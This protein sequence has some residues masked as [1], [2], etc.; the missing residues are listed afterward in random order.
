MNRYPVNLVWFKRDLRIR[1]HLPL[2][3][4][5]ESALPTVLLYIYEPELVGDAHYDDRHWRFVWESLEELN[6]QLSPNHKVCI[7]F[8]D[9]EKVFEELN[10]EYTI[11]TVF[12]HEETGIL[13]TYQRDIRMAAWFKSR[14]I[15]WDESPTNAVYR[16]LFTRKHWKPQWKSRILSEPDQPDLKALTTVKL[17]ES[18]TEKLLDYPI[19]NAWKTPADRFQKGGEVQALQTLESFMGERAASYMQAISKPELSRTFCSRL[20]PYITWGNISIKQVHLAYRAW[21]P[22]SAFKW[23]LRSFESRL[24]W[25]CHFVQKFEAEYRMEFENVN[26]GYDN[27][28]TTINPVW[29]HAWKTGNTGYPLVDACMRAVQETGYLNFRMR[30]MVVSFLTHHLWQPWQAGAVFLGRQFLDFEPGIHYPQFQMQAGTTGTNTIRIYNPVKQ[31]YEQDPKGIFIKT[32]VP[33]LTEVP[34]SFI[35]EPWNMSLMEQQMY[36]C[37]LGEHYPSPIVDVKQTYRFASDQLW[38]KKNDPGVKEE[39]KR[40]K[41]VHIKPGRREA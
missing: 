35:H 9:V 33:E 25:H 34:S 1:D 41:R 6:Q 28:R 32:W 38:A 11:K 14:A 18:L 31:S 20:S 12:S 36:N 22:G 19:P 37:E 30:S 4:A 39:A 16:G 7:A 23:N 17:S 26:R 10:R 21:Y 29:V 3:K 8:G 2:K 27:L 15:T 40:I 13:T 5:S 24:H